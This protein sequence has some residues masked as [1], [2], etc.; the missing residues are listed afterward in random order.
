MEKYTLIGPISQVLPMDDIPLK[1][2]LKDEELRTI[3]NAGIL[4]EGESIHS[5]GDYEALK[6]V[7]LKLNAK[8][9][10]LHT[11]Y[12]CLPWYCRCTYAYMFFR[13]QSK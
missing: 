13:F 7:A 3:E 8:I 4:I 11:D 6:G 5:V 12:V 10:E 1:G 2:A 9:I